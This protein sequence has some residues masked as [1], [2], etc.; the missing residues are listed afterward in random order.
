AMALPRPQAAPV[1]TATFP[2]RRFM[3]GSFPSRTETREARL[4]FGNSDWGKKTRRRLDLRQR[5]HRMRIFIFGIG[6]DRFRASAG[7]GFFKS[8]FLAPRPP[9]VGLLGAGLSGHPAGPEGPGRPS[10]R[11][12]GSAFRAHGAG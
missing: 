10:G 11:G 7:I 8:P 5:R 6:A 4:A 9:R 3:A 1:T 12:V 2:E